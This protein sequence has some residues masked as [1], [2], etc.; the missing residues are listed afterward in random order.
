MNGYVVVT[1]DMFVFSSMN[2]NRRVD[3]RSKEGCGLLGP[4]GAQ[5]PGRGARRLQT[6]SDVVDEHSGE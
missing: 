6:V 4:I 3:E 5:L 1:T 2:H